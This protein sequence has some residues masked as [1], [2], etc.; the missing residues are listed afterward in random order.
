MTVTIIVHGGAG[1]FPDDLVQPRL[2]GCTEAAQRG[3]QLLRNGGSALDA[4]QTAVETL[5][6]NPLFN[7]GIGAPLNALGEVE[8]DASIMD[9]ARLAAGAVAAVQGIKNP[10]VL[11]RRILEDGRHVLLAGEGARL[12]ARDHAVASCEPQALV[13]PAQ[14]Q[15]WQ[16]KHGT[17]GAVAIDAQGHLA[18][19]TSTGGL[20]NKLPGRVGDTA[21]IGS[22]TYANAIAGVS[23]TGIGEAIMRVVLAKAAAD[24]IASGTTAKDAAAR[25]VALVAEHTGSEAGLIL[26]TRSGE[27][28]YAH[29]SAHM[30]V[31][32][33]R[34]GQAPITDH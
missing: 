28:A 22:G 16:E 7:A 30:P 20:F 29:N 26:I 2:D 3:W 31:C 34:N 21:L 27:A 13:T 18:A 32:I 25:A 33:I 23:C 24:W 11:A 1:R 15:R 9:G 4:V 10:V 8:L 14:Q 5:E 17:V 19:A 12:F 6:D